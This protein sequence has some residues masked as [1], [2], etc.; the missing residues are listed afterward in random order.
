MAD[1]TVTALDPLTADTIRYEIGRDNWAPSA[2]NGHAWVP[3]LLHNAVGTVRLGESQIIDV[4]ILG[5]GYEGEHQF[6]TQ[7]DA[8][9]ADFFGVD[10]YQQFRGAF[11]IRA[12][13]TQSAE[14]CS[15][16]RN[17]HYGV[18]IDDDGDVAR[19]DWWNSD[20][21][22]GKAFRELPKNG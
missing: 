20:S 5:D 14:P 19:D 22:K 15:A 3:D 17:S 11:R 12:L 6:H 18:K 2:E 10:V 7:L 13:F 4:V 16:S 21:D 1:L 8:W 9:I